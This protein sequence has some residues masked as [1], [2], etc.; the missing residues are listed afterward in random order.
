[1]ELRHLRY[2]VALAEEGSFT[3]AARRTHVTQSTLSHQIRQIEDELGTRLF[4]RIGK[5]VVITT[6]GEALLQSA[7]RALREVDEGVRR[8]RAGPDP[9]TGTLRIGATHTFNIKLIPDCLAAFLQSHPSVSV[10]VREL[11]ATDVAGLVESGDLDLGITYD[12]QRRD[13]LDFEPLYIEEMVLAVAARHPFADRKRLRLVELHRQPMI[14]P[15]RSSS[16]RRIIDAALG[17][18]GA[19]PIIMAEMDSL[20]ATIELIRRT[21]LAAIVSRLAAPDA[22][23]LA[24]L[25]L[26][27]PTPL[28]TP[29]LLT[30]A[31]AVSTPA[32]RSFVGILRRLVLDHHG[33]HAS[34]AGHIK[35]S[36]GA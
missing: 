17:S 1:M 18:V 27:S 31:D 21:Q 23:D 13:R 12:P 34:A 28:R 22:H 10:T 35:A 32:L 20:A 33:A 30:R 9:L 6:A 14:L 19:E 3:R 16:T 24:I 5:R 26:E 15:T 4:D 29:G 11:F 8:V 36:R 2:F 25:A 7:T